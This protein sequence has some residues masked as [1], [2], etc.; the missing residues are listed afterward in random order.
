[1][2]WFLCCVLTLG[3]LACGDDDGGSPNHDAGD[4]DAGHTDAG[5]TDA[6]VADASK[7]DAGND[8]ATES[9]GP[10]IG[11][12]DACDA[13]LRDSCCF[14][15]NACGSDAACNALVQC[16]RGCDEADAA[17][18]CMGTCVSAGVPSTY[19]PLLICG[20]NGCADECPFS[21]P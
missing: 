13:C 14:E 5:D 11:R 20:A 18:D 21:S 7:G 4:D 17:T 19:N 9:C 6:I 16:L 8:A 10:L 2:K 3:L 15:L 12:T 1:M